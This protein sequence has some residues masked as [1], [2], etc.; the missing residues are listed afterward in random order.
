MGKIQMGLRLLCC[1]AMQLSPELA[2]PS[3]Q[4]AACPP[5]PP[6][7]TQLVGT[8]AGTIDAALWRMDSCLQAAASPCPTCSKFQLALRMLLLHSL[9]APALCADLE[10]QASCI[11]GG[12]K[13]K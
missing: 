3:C 5:L 10:M 4:Y 11:S 13:P 2:S 1:P 12:W 8:S 9:Q 6:C 7:S